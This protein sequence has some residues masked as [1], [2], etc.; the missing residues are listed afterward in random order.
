MIREKVPFPHV[1]GYVCNH[2]CESGCKR[3]A[4]NSPVSIRN[5][6]RYAAE[7]DTEQ[8]WRGKGFHKDR[9]GKRIAVI[10]GGPAG[11][12]AAY[13][14]NKLGHDVTVYEKQNVAGGYMALGIPEFRAPT[15]AE[16]KENS[17]AACFAAA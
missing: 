7:R 10:G 2:R 1:L 5:L 4:L 6:K 3:T 14:L 17:Q 12:T 9:T 15:Q 11:L 16:A 8:V 13:Y